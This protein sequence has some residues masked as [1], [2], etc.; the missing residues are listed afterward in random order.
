MLFKQILVLSMLFLVNACGFSAVHG[1]PPA[2]TDD[3][4]IAS[5]LREIQINTTEDR[6]GQLFKTRL[7]DVINP[8]SLKQGTPQYTL[9]VRIEPE[10]SAL[11]IEQDSS[12]SRYKVTIR[13]YYTLKNNVTKTILDNGT[14]SRF[15]GFDRVESDYAT[16]VSEKDA[17]RETVES[18]ADDF[19]WRLTTTL[20]SQN[21][22]HEG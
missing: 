13:A 15:S 19:K 8:Q 11:A 6:Y 20:L 17:V 2:N 4:A 14:L 12:T 22:R 21:N 16:Y 3:P 10:I 7:E 5:K 18:L 9:D 1:T